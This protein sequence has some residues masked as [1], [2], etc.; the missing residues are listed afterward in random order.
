MAARIND[1]KQIYPTSNSEP[2][3]TLKRMKIPKT[4]IVG[5]TPFNQNQRYLV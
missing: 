3:T 1:S 5:S 4:F 2:C